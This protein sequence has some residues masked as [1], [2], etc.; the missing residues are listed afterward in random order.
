MRKQ[1]A[2]AGRHIISTVPGVT[3]SRNLSEEL[4]SMAGKV[5]VEEFDGNPTGEAGAPFT[6]G[7]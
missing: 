1:G 7:R 6:G 4:S 3:G 5:D 2:R